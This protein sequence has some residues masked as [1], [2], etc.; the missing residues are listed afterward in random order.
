VGT[1]LTGT[2]ITECPEGADEVG[3]VDVPGNSQTTRASSRTKCRWMIF[4]M[5]PGS[6]SPK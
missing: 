6:P 3:T 4:G 2:L 5:G 1:V